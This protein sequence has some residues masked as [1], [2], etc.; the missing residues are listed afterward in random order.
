[1][2][3][4]AHASQSKEYNSSDSLKNAELSNPSPLEH[5]IHMI[6]E[7]LKYPVTPQKEI[8]NKREETSNA[9]N[10]HPDFI[11]LQELDLLLKEKNGE[12]L[13][14][15]ESCRVLLPQKATRN[16]TKSEVKT[17]TKQKLW[18][19]IH[20]PIAMAISL[21]IHE[22]IL[23]TLQEV[24]ECRFELMKVVIDE[25]NNGE[26]YNYDIIVY[27]TD[28][29]IDTSTPHKDKSNS[30]SMEVINLVTESPIIE[31]WSDQPSVT[32]KQT[33]FVPKIPRLREW[34][35][36]WD[37]GKFSS[38]LFEASVEVGNVMQ[39]VIIVGVLSFIDLFK[40]AD[41]FL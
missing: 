34:D 6:S 9:L 38:F 4:M 13:L 12:V 37:K 40:Y 15:A 14:W 41:Q 33:V 32:N 18:D 5:Q 8:S 31:Y 27:H 3:N 19:A 7:T 2:K 17:T 29:D 11:L 1:M 39:K 30:N 20:Q 16:K 23:S 28:T 24:E 21:P 25:E 26:N 10:N 35:G 22:K 36:V